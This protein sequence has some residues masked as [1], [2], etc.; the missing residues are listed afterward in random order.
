[1]LSNTFAR[2]LTAVR[3]IR[4]C[5]QHLL[6][7]LSTADATSTQTSSKERE[8]GIVKRFSKDKGY[9]FISKNS[10]GSDCFVQYVNSK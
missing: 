10:D 3:P 6:R 1:M 9:G 4:H 7:S 8:T 5:Q 2:L